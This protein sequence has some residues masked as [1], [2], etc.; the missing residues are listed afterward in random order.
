M[1]TLQPQLLSVDNFAPYG[2][3]IE[4]AEQSNNQMNGT[5]A[6]FDDL[7]LIDA[8]EPSPNE[9]GAQTSISIVRSQIPT[10]LPHRFN[11]V[12]CHPLCSQAFIPR[13]KFQFYVVVAPPCPESENKVDAKDLRAFITNGHQ[14][15][16]YFSGTWHM[17]LIALAPDQEFL[18]VDQ[19]TRQGNLREHQ[20]DDFDGTGNDI[21]ATTIAA[22]GPW[23]SALD[24]H[25]AT[26][27]AAT[28]C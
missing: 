2:H 27:P 3:V 19:A 26:R 25:V 7:A 20:F 13:S 15:I 6:R 18:V 9:S 22:R 12:E 5:F 4:A 10:L 28:S 17:P 21:D 8:K 11:L 16:S 1:I 14:G 24:L 23:A